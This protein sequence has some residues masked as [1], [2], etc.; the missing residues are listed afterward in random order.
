[1]LCVLNVL[2]ILKV[3]LYYVLLKQMALNYQRKYRHRQK[4]RGCTGAFISADNT[5]RFHIQDICFQ[6]DDE[7]HILRFSSA[8]NT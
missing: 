8:I 3:L 6:L 5:H 2:K 7:M 4:N 1:M